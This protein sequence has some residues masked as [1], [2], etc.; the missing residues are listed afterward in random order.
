MSDRIVLADK[1]YI[2]KSKLGKKGTSAIKKDYQRYSF[3]DKI[4][5]RC[6]YEPDRPTLACEDC[7]AYQG[8]FRFWQEKEVKG[9]RYIG[10]PLGDR[11]KAK[12]HMP[13]LPIDDRRVSPK[14]PHSIEI[15]ATLYDFQ[16]KAVEEMVR[17]KYGL[18]QSM[19]RT[20]KTVMAAAI[21]CRLGLKTIIFAH[22][23]DLVEQFLDTFH[24]FTNVLEV[25]KFHS[26]RIVGICSKPSD[27]D[28]Y[29][30][31]LATY[32]QFISAGG[33]KRLQAIRKKFGVVI[34][35]EVHK[36]NASCYSKVL[37]TFSSKYRFGMSATP[38]RKD[39]LEFV[40]ENI[41]GPVV[42]Q[43]E[44][45]TLTPVVSLIE[46]G[47]STR[48][49]YKI[50][51]YAMRFLEEQEKRNKL[52]LKYLVNDIKKGRHIV[53]PVIFQSQVT[54]FVEALN[55]KFG[56][57]VAE[58]FHGKVPKKKRK[59]I[60][61]LARSGEVKCIIAMRSMLTGVNVPRW[62]TLFEI[63]PISNP[64]N[65]EQEIRRICTPMEGKPKPYI[66]FFIDDLSLSKGCFRTCLQTFRK[67]GIRF[68][69]KTKHLIPY[70]CGSRQRSSSDDEEYKPKR[71]QRRRRL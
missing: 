31:C 28:T 35:D 45:T 7:P 68:T 17:K 23:N 58:G 65:F 64:P 2:P 32:Q 6:E 55:K 9:V 57:T 51:T 50:W 42:H 47:V 56:K 46:T 14:L 25:E 26:T 8:N 71:T 39:G 5:A 1:I 36:G 37:N 62:N 3:I 38:Y 52:I 13:N 22:Q 4:C 66:R 41:V 29:S 70:Y 59:E 43:T 53:V 44:A 19:P 27:Y 10:I 60:L 48:Y 16:E 63:M 40:I 61:D 24:K 67:E 54:F 33:K 12:E 11:A 18:L 34:T 30:I 69:E 15:T 49:N 21:T 20:G